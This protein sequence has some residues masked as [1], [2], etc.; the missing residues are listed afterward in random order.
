[1][2]VRAGRLRIITQQSQ[3]AA[4][5]QQ[6]NCRYKLHKNKPNMPNRPNNSQDSDEIEKMV[7]ESITIGERLPYFGF[8]HPMSL[9]KCHL[10]SAFLTKSFCTL[11]PY[12]N[13]NCCRRDISVGTEI[14]PA[15]S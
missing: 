13:L 15:S 3:N 7:N 5:T 8:A 2:A 14:N 9:N 6:T 1:M 12:R 4:I 10:C 11:I